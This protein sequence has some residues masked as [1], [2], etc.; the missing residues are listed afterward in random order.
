MSTLRFKTVSATYEVRAEDGYLYRFIVSD[1]ETIVR[2]H[3]HDER[4]VWNHG[5]MVEMQDTIDESNA[6]KPS[7]AVQRPMRYASFDDAIAAVLPADA[8]IVLP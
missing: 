4:P 1:K 3:A 8:T 2:R 5:V 6:W 7:C